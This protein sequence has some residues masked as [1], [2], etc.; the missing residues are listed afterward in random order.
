MDKLDSNLDKKEGISG[1]L[2]AEKSHGEFESRV[3][4]HISKV[5]SFSRRDLPVREVIAISL[6]YNARDE[7]REHFLKDI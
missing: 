3:K 1:R 4:N 6:I 2:K 7:G 5:S